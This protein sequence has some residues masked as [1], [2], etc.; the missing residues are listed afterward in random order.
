MNNWLCSRWACC[1]FARYFES[2]TIYNI[3]FPRKHRSQHVPDGWVWCKV[4]HLLSS[5]PLRAEFSKNRVGHINNAVVFQMIR[6]PEIGVQKSKFKNFA[7]HEETQIIT[8]RWLFY[9]FI[10]LFL[11]FIFTIDFIILRY[12][13]MG[14][15]FLFQIL[16]SIYRQYYEFWMSQLKIEFSEKSFSLDL[17]S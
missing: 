3:S 16:H 5:L 12:I 11:R 9:I 13:C 2:L 15:S 10:Y 17:L 4:K 14:K 6:K 7:T 1:K 8:F